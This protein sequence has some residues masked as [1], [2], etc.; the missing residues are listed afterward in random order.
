M[1]SQAAAGGGVATTDLVCV[2]DIIHGV[3]LLEVLLGVDPQKKH[4]E[5]QGQGLALAGPRLPSHPQSRAQSYPIQHLAPSQPAQHRLGE[6]G[7][8]DT[9]PQ[10][11]R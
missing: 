9:G 10:R 1:S 11:D 4:K 5:G 2:L 7:L 8:K 3:L 6:G